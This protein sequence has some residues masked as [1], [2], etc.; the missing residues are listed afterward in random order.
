MLV[1]PETGKL[2]KLLPIQKKFL[3]LAFTPGPGGDLP[4]RDI[5]YSTLKKGGKSTFNAMCALYTICA[6]GGRYAEG[7]ILANDFDQAKSRVF[8][9][10]CRIVEA[11]PTLRAKITS[12][13][14]LFSNGSFIQALASDYKGAAGSAPT[15]IGVDESW[16]FTTEASQRLVAECCPTPTRKP[17]V[18]MT[19]TYAGILGQSEVLERQVKRA[20]QGEEI[21]PD[22]FVQPGLIAYIGHSMIA[23]WQTQKWF[24]EQK[25][26]MRPADFSRQMLNEFTSGETGFIDMEQY[27]R[28]VNPDLRARI[29]DPRL[30]VFIG[31]DASTKR[32]ST[33]IAVCAWNKE[34]QRV[35]VVNHQIFQPTPQ[36]PLNFEA[37]IERT[38]L[39]YRTR[40]HVRQVL[41][42]PSQMAS[43]S[44]RLKNQGLPME[45]YL[46]TPA[47]LG[48]IA[49]NLYNLITKRSIDFYHSPEI[50][51]AMSGA[52]ARESSRGWS[53][54]KTRQSHKIDIVIAL[55]MAAFAAHRAGTGRDSFEE[56]MLLLDMRAH[57]GAYP[58]ARDAVT[59]AAEREMENKKRELQSRLCRGCGLPIGPG[60]HIA[61]GEDL[62]HVECPTTVEEIQQNEQNALKKLPPRMFP[63]GTA[64]AI[65]RR[66]GGKK[67]ATPDLPK[68]E[69]DDI[70]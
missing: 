18:R 2:F 70:R 33:A 57:P 35:E 61:V 10:C 1:N 59:R 3:Q 28:C 31:V 60:S 29:V 66:Q 55:A 65:R 63:E 4:Y 5:L 7:Y 40:Y 17:S 6:L 19:T 48:D 30:T 22:L 43:T 46:Q 41:F 69:N 68:I 50:R 12:D 9:M 67:K 25:A 15:Y 58:Q 47:N 37:T 27:D 45:E 11:S 52:V 38:L 23:P 56:A 39:E 14:I 24:E 51:L 8:T 26:E 36:D 20:L 16:A 49:T 54:G 21:E 42:D 34:T 13:L 53:I 64:A 62:Y 32:D 44:Q